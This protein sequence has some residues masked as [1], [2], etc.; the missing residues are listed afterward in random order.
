MLL[1]LIGKKTRSPRQGRGLAL[2]LA[3]ACHVSFMVLG[4]RALLLEWVRRRSERLR[5]RARPVD[6]RLRD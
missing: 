6:R 2:G 3:L 1:A 4:W 5:G